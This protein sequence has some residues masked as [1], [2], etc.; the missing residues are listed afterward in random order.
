MY[1]H[2]ALLQLPSCLLEQT[3]IVE[4]QR[5]GRTLDRTEFVSRSPHDGMEAS[6]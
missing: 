2:T 1:V 6:L 3:T 5:S 4:T